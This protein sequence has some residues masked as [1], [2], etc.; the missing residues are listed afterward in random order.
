MTF[1]VRPL[2][3]MTPII[4]KAVEEDRMERHIEELRQQNALLKAA[5]LILAN[6]D[7]DAV[8]SAIAKATGGE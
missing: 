3:E 7:W 4:M 6:N 8:E 5:M 2:N 1:K